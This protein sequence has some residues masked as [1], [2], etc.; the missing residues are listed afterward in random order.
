M[1]KQFLLLTLMRALS[2]ALISLTLTAF[3]EAVELTNVPPYSDNWTIR[4][5]QTKDGL[6]QNTVNA[7][8]QTRDGYLWVGTS[9]GLARFDGARFRS[10][11]LHEGLRS[12]QISTLLEDRQSV[13][14][15]GTLTTPCRIEQLIKIARTATRRACKT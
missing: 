12:V 15:V 8:V 13:L 5:W 3:A 2:A 4:S 6:P 14:W 1:T 11:G 10:Y 7:I 9:G